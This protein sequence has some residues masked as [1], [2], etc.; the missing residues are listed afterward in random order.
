MHEVHLGI[1][2]FA[3]D[4][5]LGGGVEVELLRG[6]EG[7]GAIGKGDL[8]LSLGALSLIP[9]ACRVGDVGSAGAV[10]EVIIVITLELH[11]VGD[12]RVGGQV[13]WGLLKTRVAETV[14]TVDDSA[15]VS[16]DLLVAPV[17]A[18]GS[19]SCGDEKSAR[20]VRKHAEVLFAEKI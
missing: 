2:E 1:V 13:D 5:V 19:E 14:L 12:V 15:P 17:L 20:D 10:S 7:R 18:G 6:E 3:V 11:L 8:E 4:G 16:T 9:E